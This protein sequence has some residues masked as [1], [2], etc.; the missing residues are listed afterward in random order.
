MSSMTHHG[1]KPIDGF[2][3]CGISVGYHHAQLLPAAAPAACYNAPN[4]PVRGRRHQRCHQARQNL[5]P[6]HGHKRVVSSVF[7]CQWD[8]TDLHQPRAGSCARRRAHC[9]TVKVPGQSRRR[10]A[11][12]GL[13]ARWER[14]A[15][16]S[17]LPRNQRGDCARSRGSQIWRDIRMAMPTLAMRRRTT[18]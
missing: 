12:E 1:G 16:N 7:C 4:K 14:K 10:R 6:H 18:S 13:K 9:W 5:Q 17:N 8:V 2:Y 15:C 11:G 3:P